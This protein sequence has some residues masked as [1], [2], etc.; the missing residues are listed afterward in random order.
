MVASALVLNTICYLNVVGTMHAAKLDVQEL[1]QRLA[2]AQRWAECVAMEVTIKSEDRNPIGGRPKF[3]Q[4]RLNIRRQGD[5]YESKG[6]SWLADE[7]GRIDMTSENVQYDLCN[8]QFFLS[9]YAHGPRPRAVVVN[10]SWRQRLQEMVDYPPLGPLSGRFGGTK[11]QGL[12][13]VLAKAQDL[14]LG[15]GA[16]VNGIECHALEATS[17]YGK[18]TVWLAPGKGYNCV[19]CIWKSAGQDLVDDIPYEQRWPELKGKGTTTI[20]ECKEF[21]QVTDAKGTS[22]FVPSCA[23]LEMRVEPRSPGLDAVDFVEHY[24][25]TNVDLKP[26]FASLGAF[27]ADVPDGTHVIVVEEPGLRYIWRNGKVVPDLENWSVDQ[28][29]AVVD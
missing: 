29:D 25:V 11:H 9:Y 13:Q 7:Q 18:M 22:F 26:D 14:R 17:Q 3:V 27:R 28:I 2:D 19:R 10:R 1:V 5:L 16:I 23:S 15:E 21:L 24:L 4:K 20:F 6:Y 12:A 8:G